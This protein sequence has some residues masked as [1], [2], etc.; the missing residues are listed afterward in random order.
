MILKGDYW[1]TE[2]N[3]FKLQIK[4]NRDQK[5][6]ENML[7]GWSCISYGYAPRTSEDIYVFER[8][9][10]SDNEW[11]NFLNSSKAIKLIEIER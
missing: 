9:F 3:T 5:E 10:H 8:K 6:I 4:T 7:P 11:I 2:L 1:R